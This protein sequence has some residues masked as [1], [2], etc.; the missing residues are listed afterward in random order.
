MVDRNGYYTS[1]LG[2]NGGTRC[3]VEAGRPSQIGQLI[4]RGSNE[5][6]ERKRRDNSFRGDLWKESKGETLLPKHC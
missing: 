4:K 5:R 2:S 3:G 6:L 1:G